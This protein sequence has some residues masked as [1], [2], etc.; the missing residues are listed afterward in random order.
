MIKL[1]KILILIIILIALII[2][3]KYANVEKFEDNVNKKL[4]DDNDIYFEDNSNNVTRQPIS[5]NETNIPISESKKFLNI[6]E[7]NLISKTSNIDILTCSNN[8]SLIIMISNTDNI[9]YISYDN[10]NRWIYKKLPKLINYSKLYLIEL[11]INNYLLILF[12]EKNNIYISTSL[13]DTWKLIS[14]NRGNDVCYSNNLDYIY[15]A[16][17]NGILFNNSENKKINYKGCDNECLFNYNLYDGIFKFNIINRD[18]INNNNITNIDCLPSGETIVYS[19]DRKNI[20]SLKYENDNW[21]TASGIFWKNVGFNKP[22]TG[23]EIT[24]EQLLNILKSRTQLSPEEVQELAINNLTIN[25]YIRV[26]N[27]Y[28]KPTN[29]H[30]ISDI[31]YIKN[32]IVMNDELLSKNGSIIV[33]DSNNLYAYLYFTNNNY[34]LTEKKNLEIIDI[35]SE[36]C[37]YEKDN[38]NLNI[39]KLIKY[40]ISSKQG[41]MLLINNNML[42]T[43]DIYNIDK[44]LPVKT[45][46]KTIK[47]FAINKNASKGIIID[48][49]G[50]LYINDDLENYFKGESKFEQINLNFS[51]DY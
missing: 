6:A 10:G 26:N 30:L 43:N 47:N 49:D 38:C 46:E 44:I 1:N 12:G 27:E 9:M 5:F 29:I 8:G 19:I 25:S 14:L 18:E 45:F 36:V 31:K 24:N 23:I 2:L 51:S 7:E 40:N 34:K 3:Y 15:I 39:Q 21:I 35:Q 37:K 17:N 13:G 4:I 41:Y 50:N 42:L 22:T 48:Y 16:T 11:N 20:Y 28:Y 32:L 33:N